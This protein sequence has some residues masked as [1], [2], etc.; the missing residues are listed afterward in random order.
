MQKSTLN[1]GLLKK[2]LDSSFI[3][4]NK[5]VEYSVRNTRI[6]H[7][8]TQTSSVIWTKI[9]ILMKVLKNSHYSIFDEHFKLIPLHNF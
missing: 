4:K 6:T 5:F 7:S 9:K 3:K 1:I 2:K 8:I